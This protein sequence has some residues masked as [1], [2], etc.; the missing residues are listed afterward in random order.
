MNLQNEL[1]HELVIKNIVTN[2]LISFF[3]MITKLYQHQIKIY[4]YGKKKYKSLET[5]WY[6]WIF[7]S[8]ILFGYYFLM[9]LLNLHS[10]NFCGY[11]HL[12]FE[13][14]GSA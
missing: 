8:I 10:L 12:I 6:K 11:V 1:Q 3:F 14:A 9:C 2:N 5:I 13:L 4:H 7:K